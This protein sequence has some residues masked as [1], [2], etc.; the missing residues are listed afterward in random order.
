ME[1]SIH[2][3]HHLSCKSPPPT[4][5]SAAAAGTVT[6]TSGATATPASGATATPASGVTPAPAVTTVLAPGVRLL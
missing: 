2:M 6:P 3:V 4:L 5:N 1:A